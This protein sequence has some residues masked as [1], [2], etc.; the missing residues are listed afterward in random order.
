[1][2]II[3]PGKLPTE[4]SGRVKCGKCETVF[5]FKAGE[6]T[7]MHALDQRD[8]DYFKVTCPFEGC[9]HANSVDVRQMK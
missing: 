3:T 6:A 7:L 2:K 1:M 9:G 5:E 4:K 8:S